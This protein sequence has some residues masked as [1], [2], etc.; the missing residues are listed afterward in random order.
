MVAIIENRSFDKGLEVS[1]PA[2]LV[3]TW[4]EEM[5][6]EISSLFPLGKSEPFWPFQR[7]KIFSLFF[8]KSF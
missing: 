2:N 7:L 4:K 3:R 5:T 6:F 1:D 8:R